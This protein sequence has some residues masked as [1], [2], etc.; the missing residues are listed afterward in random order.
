MDGTGEPEQQKLLTISDEDVSPGDLVIAE[1]TL[2]LNV[3]IGAGYKYEMLL[4]KTSFV[5]GSE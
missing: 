5:D 1:G 4:E 3:D 2:R